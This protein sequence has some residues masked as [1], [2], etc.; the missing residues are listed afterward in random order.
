MKFNLMLILDCLQINFKAIGF[1][2][3]NKKPLRIAGWLFIIAL[4]VNFPT[5]MKPANLNGLFV[6]FSVLALFATKRSAFAVLG[7]LLLARVDYNRYLA[8]CNINCLF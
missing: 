3:G 4:G 1:W 7:K 5:I 2:L 6:E 8:S